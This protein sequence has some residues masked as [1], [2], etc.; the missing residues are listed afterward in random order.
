M[1]K[2]VRLFEAR[3]NDLLGR[4]E[5]SRYLDLILSQERVNNGSLSF[6][7]KGI[8]DQGLKKHMM[9]RLI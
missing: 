5:H 6:P 1:V 3:E 4:L 2:L 7:Q 8:R 9:M